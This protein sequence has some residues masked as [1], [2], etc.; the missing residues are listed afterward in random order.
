MALKSRAAGKG[1]KIEKNSSESS[2][3]EQKEKK[4]NKS[5]TGATNKTKA[6]E[7]PLEKHEETK[8]KMPAKPTKETKKKIVVSSSSE[9]SLYEPEWAPPKR[10]KSAYLFFC[11]EKRPEVSESN[12][13][14]A[15]KVILSLLAKQ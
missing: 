4:P 1:K 13:D 8:S 2:E 11:E 9:S 14:E 6:A 7:K 5:K 3:E 10:G 12:P 15:P